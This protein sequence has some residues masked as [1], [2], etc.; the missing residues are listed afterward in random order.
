M[1]SAELFLKRL[2]FRLIG[3]FRSRSTYLPTEIPRESFRRI[4]IIRQHD[5]LGD[6]LIATPAIRAVRKRFPDAF[7][8]LVAREYTAPVVA[9]NPYLD[10]VIIFY[11]KLWRWDIAKARNFWKSV[12]NGFTVTIV[13]NTISRSLSSDLIA[14]VSG[15]RYIVGPDHLLLDERSQEPIYN[16]PVHRLP[17]KRREIDRNLDIVRSLGCDENDFEYDLVLTDEEV[18]R[19]ERVFHSLS[20]PSGKIVVGVHFGAL[21]PAKCFPLD[22]LAEVID[23]MVGELKVEIALLVGPDDAGRLQLLLSKL[24]HNVHAAPFMPLR[25]LA[26][27]MRHCELILCNDTGTFHIASSQRIPTVS[28]HSIS[29]PEIWKPPHERHIPVRAED[30]KIESITVEQ[31]QSAVKRAFKNFTKHSGRQ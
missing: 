27:F 14:V 17:G 12:R 9:Q 7:I 11:E 22:K 30:G 1:R 23:W 6:L 18:D 10:E 20:I 4:L 13:L 21:N 19:A 2:L 3:S 29:D 31:V 16:V 24:H 8:A 26:A 15:A 28:F 5:Q 25:V